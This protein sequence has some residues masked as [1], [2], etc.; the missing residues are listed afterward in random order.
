MLKK[1]KAIFKKIIKILNKHNNKNVTCKNEIRSYAEIRKERENK[2]L[3]LKREQERLIKNEKE[4][5]KLLPKIK[6]INIDLLLEKSN[7]IQSKCINKPI[8][9][10]NNE[11]CFWEHHLPLKS[12]KEH[13]L[14]PNNWALPE[15]E[16]IKINEY[17][18][19]LAEYANLLIDL[20]YANNNKPIKEFLNNYL[21]VLSPWIVFPL[22]N[23][24]TIGWRMGLGEEYIY[25]YTNFIRSLSEEEFRKYDANYKQPEYMFPNSFSLNL[26]NYDIKYEIKQEEGE[27][28]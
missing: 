17:Q 18:A 23:S 19:S 2:E 9:N 11:I 15:N 26:L 10:K 20:W 25:F 1:L 22:Y 7:Y 4:K 24:S 6:K 14:E 16:I 3:K 12:L 28:K 5:N 8:T 13:S 21:D 27:N